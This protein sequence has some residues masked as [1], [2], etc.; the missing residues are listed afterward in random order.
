MKRKEWMNAVRKQAKKERQ[1]PVKFLSKRYMSKARADS[2]LGTPIINPIT[3]EYARYTRGSLVGM[4]M[5]YPDGTRHLSDDFRQ[6]ILNK[7]SH[8][9]P[10]NAV[11][12][13]SA[14]YLKVGRTE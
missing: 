1:A 3:K 14:D 11:K 9:M 5:R 10:D 6:S 13:I 7:S 12:F 2:I 8:G 4:I